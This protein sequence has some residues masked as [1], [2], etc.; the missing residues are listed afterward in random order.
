MP[1]YD[2]ERT[3]GH[4][5]SRVLSTDY[6]C[7][8]E[9]IVVDD[10]SRDAT[11]QILRGLSDPRLRV[12]RHDRNRG[13]GAALRTA[14]EAAGGTHIVPF[15]ADLEYSPSDLG[16][17]IQPVIDGRC[18]VV[19][20]TRLFGAR[21]VYQS[22]RHAMGN[23]VLTLTANILFDAY[24]SDLHSCLKL[25]PRDLF[26]SLDLSDSGFGLDTEL[27]AKILKAGVRPFEVPISY[28]S[29][30]VDE[31]KKIA[32]RDA[33]KCVELLARIRFA[34][35]RPAAPVTVARAEADGRPHGA[36]RTREEAIED[37]QVMLHWAHVP[38]TR[39]RR[40][41]RSRHL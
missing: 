29:R 17:L 33:V 13:K 10:G 1:V 40:F 26:R 2:E 11:P 27:T 21:T 34:Y 28:H 18:D 20:G 37:A 25:V 39:R 15:D 19:Y 22:F 31:G 4:T 23:R 41:G 6:P 30:T 32:W 7:E 12:L 8:I 35:A 36:P 38:R 3:V 24:I 5:I 9:L 16:D 14:V